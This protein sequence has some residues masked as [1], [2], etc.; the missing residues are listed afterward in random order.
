MPAPSLTAVRS[1]QVRD[2]VIIAESERF[3]GFDYLRAIFSVV[4]VVLHANLLI[5]LTGKLGMSSLAKVL[6]AN[7]GYLAVPIFFQISI[8]LF[9]LKS[10]QAGWKYLIKKRLPKLISL[11][12]FW[13]VSKLIF[14]FTLTR[15]SPKI[16]FGFSSLGSF[17]GFLISG[18]YSVFYFF[19]SLI[20]LTAIAAIVANY[21]RRFSRK[22]VQ[23]ISYFMLLA[24]CLLVFSFPVIDSFMGERE[25]LTQIHNP[26]AFLPYVFTAAIAVQE[27]RQGA[28][29]EINSSLRLKLYLLA[30]LF[31]GF[32]LLEWSL[33]A[34]FPQYSR[35]SLVFGSWF[36]L[37]LALLSEQKPPRLVKIISSASLGI[38][39]LHVFFT[40][41]TL[42][43]ESL[44]AYVPGIGPLVRFLI[45][46]IGSI[47]LTF[48]FKNTK[49]LKSFV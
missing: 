47:S 5:V 7:I 21:F 1:P 48:V 29:K 23:R 30:T 18:G 4:V 28:L 42:F 15:E 41:H 32:T 26:L 9:F 2:R 22:F 27:F 20:V 38:Y 6:S 16:E 37:Y 3:E 45:A 40:D 8:F 14:D 43:L 13:S 36:L 19:F 12:L 10:E 11:Y 35:L 33:F 46:L 34:K 25:F 17:I 44:S 49:F 31:L 39:G 24:S